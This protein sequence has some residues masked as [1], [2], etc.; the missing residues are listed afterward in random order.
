M[1]ERLAKLLELDAPSGFEKP[2]C[3][4][5]EKELS[6]FGKVWRDAMG[7]LYARIGE[8]EKSV[9]LASHMDEVGFMVQHVYPNGFLKFTP[10]GG[11]DE[12]ILPDMEVK[13]LGRKEVY[14][15]ISTK[16]PHITS[17]VERNQPIKM[18]ELFIDTGLNQAELESLDISTGTPITPSSTLRVN[19]SIV[20]A[21]ALDDRAGCYALLRVAEEL[22][23]TRKSVYLVATVQEEL[24]LRGA[25]VAASNVKANFAL[26]V[27]ATVAADQPGLAEEKRPSTMGGGAVLTAMDRSLVANQE[28]LFLLKEV[29]KKRGISTQIKKPSYGGTDAGELQFAGI[30]SGV[31]SIPCRYIHSANSMCN[32][33]DVDQVV[34]LLLAFIEE[35]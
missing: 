18:D 26:A 2:V 3:D 25:R 11:W 13:L 4:F 27:E 22:K 23:S 33:H 30:P 31:V 35:F 9:L 29:A 5:L 12:R 20:K 1:D 14:G 15:V 28:L 32:L 10:L 17:D 8:G 34:K 21:K 6:R 16:P 19:G 7:N 24:G